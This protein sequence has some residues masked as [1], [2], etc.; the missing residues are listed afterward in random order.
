M[1]LKEKPNS[2]AV[3]LSAQLG[4]RLG[5]RYVVTRDSK[6]REFRTG[7]QVW[8]EPDGAIMCQEAHG[9]ML[10]EDVVRATEGWAIE[11]DA[12]WAAA[13]RDELER[14]L[15]ELAALCP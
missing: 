9:W 13:T 6:N 2:L 3:S 7:D 11:P 14:K 8:M 15:A 1:K 12:N 4:M 10:P 5:M